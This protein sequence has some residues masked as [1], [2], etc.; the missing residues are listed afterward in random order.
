MVAQQN[1]QF[2][3]Y[4]SARAPFWRGGE[5]AQRAFLIE[6]VAQQNAQFSQYSNARAPF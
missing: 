2:S 4:S 6:M 1:A 3:Q 5:N